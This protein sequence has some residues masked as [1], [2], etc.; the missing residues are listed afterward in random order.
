[1]TIN[2]WFIWRKNLRII[3]NYIH[4]KNDRFVADTMALILRLERRKMGPKAKAIFISAENAE[5]GLIIPTMVLENVGWVK[6][7]VCNRSRWVR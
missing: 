3:R 4:V 7:V 1:L 2:R 5:V 6:P